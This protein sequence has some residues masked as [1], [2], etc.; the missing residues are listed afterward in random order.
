M[1]PDGSIDIVYILSGTDL[2][3]Q[4]IT[5]A[6]A[7]VHAETVVETG[8]VALSKPK[9]VSIKSGAGYF[10]HI[11]LKKYISGSQVDIGYVRLSASNTVETPYQTLVNLGANLAHPSIDKDDDDSMLYLVFENADT[12]RIYL[13]TYDASTVTAVTPP[14]QYGLPVELQDDTYNISTA[15]VLAATGAL[16]PVVKRTANKELYVFWR[17]FKGS[18]KYGVA[19]YCSTDLYGLGY[20]AY[21]QDYV[22]ASENIERFRVVIDDHGSAHLLLDDTTQAAYAK[23]RLEGLGIQ[24][25]TT[26]IVTSAV[27]TDLAVNITPN[28]RILHA[29]AD[30]ST[31]QGHV[32]TSTGAEKESLRDIY[33]M[34]SDVLLGAYRNS[35]SV[36][37]VQGNFFE[38][39]A[40]I[41]RLYEYNN[42][43]AAT[44]SVTWGT[45]ANTLI[46]NASIAVRAFNRVAT[47]TI[48]ANAP[49]GVVVPLNNVCYVQLPD[50]DTSSTL[51][52]Q[53]KPFGEGILDRHNRNTVPLFWNIGGV[54]YTKFAPFRLE[55]GSTVVIGSQ[56]TDEMLS[57]LGASS[58][59]PDPANHAYTSTTYIANTDSHN[60]ALGKLDAAVTAGAN[61]VTNG[62]ESIAAGVTSVTVTLSPARA[63]ATYRLALAMENT[64]DTDPMIQPMVVTA[65]STGSFT[66]SWNVATDSA[67]YKLNWHLMDS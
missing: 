34:S 58:V 67:N 59:A 11:V 5:T 66:V 26:N 52:L 47:Y 19:V 39:N 4:R 36:L 33:T 53:I 41:R 12:G 21:V 63:A 44:G 27:L 54:L 62:L 51:T 22:A 13:R 42:L 10:L 24:I 18:G 38:E 65:K 29:Y 8:L 48:A 30:S 55:G 57:W 35:D 16:E 20:K 49:G 6:G 1:N 17:H 23:V 40:T 61:N 14:A 9:L 15:A 37:S 46:I 28:G 3:Y 2:A 32:L 60:A 31:L 64:T 25:T 43:F 45:P 56:I 50:D 7:A